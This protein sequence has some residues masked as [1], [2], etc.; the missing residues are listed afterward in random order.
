MTGLCL[1]LAGVVWASLPL[2]HFTLAWQHSIEKIRW[3]ED[4][5]VT[6]AG[7]LLGEA[8]IRGNGAGMEIPDDAVLRDGAWHYRRRLP[9]LQPLHAGRTPE[10]GDYQLC[11]EHGCQ[12]LSHWLG[13]PTTA[14]PAVDFWAC[15]TTTETSRPL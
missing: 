5:Q 9:P 11:T 2:Q 15:E 8:R 13:P 1:G 3:E 6:S 10:A 12:A 14:T 7:L 4:Y